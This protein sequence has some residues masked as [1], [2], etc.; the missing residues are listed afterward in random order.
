MS[1]GLQRVVVRAPGKVN[2]SLA[3]GGQDERGYHQLATVFQAV[4]LYETVTAARWEA[5][6]PDPGA[7]ELTLSAHV[8][9]SVPLD[10]TNLVLRAAELLR[11]RWGITEGARLHVEKHVPVAGGMGGGSAD[12]AATLL[13]LSLLW[14]ID[15][16]A[17]E[18]RA[19]GGILG[20]DVPFA[21][22][23]HTALGR[24]KGDDLTSVLTSGSWHW[25]LAVPGGHLSTPQVYARFDALIREHGRTVAAV[26]E[27][28]AAQLQALRAGDVALLGQTLHNDLQGAAFSLDP[29]LEPIIVAAEQAGACGAIVSGSGPTI[30]VL[31]HDEAH[32]RSLREVLRA[33]GLLQECLV[34]EGSV[35]G[36][37]VL[38]TTPAPGT[39]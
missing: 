32:A 23:G 13:A 29:S 22:I 4:G 2:L 28:D 21:M 17:E 39:S 3:V 10:G 34:T 33:T 35:P 24:G 20:A 30:A 8:A 6:A 12:A 18:L 38:E 19:L 27:P 26:P 36:A 25:V 16:P 5:G 15:A 1:A 11:E 14:G 31:A 7:L 37:R 9:G